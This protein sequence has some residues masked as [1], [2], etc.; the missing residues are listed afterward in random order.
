MSAFQGLL[1]LRV[2]LHLLRDDENVIVTWLRR[3]GA[4]IRALQSVIVLALPDETATVFNHLT[5][6]AQFVFW[7][8]GW[9][10]VLLSMVRLGRVWCGVLC[11][12]GALS[13]WAS[14]NGQ[15]RSIPGWMR[16]NGWPFAAFV[17]TTVY[18]QMVSA[19]PYPKA[20]LL[21]LVPVNTAWAFMFWLW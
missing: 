19:Y 8:I 9:P 5:V 16:W 13:E 14:G 20:V 11:P 4:Q 7:G 17:L 21:A 1:Q 10:F 12:Q 6:A 2:I 18:G 3:H 15:R